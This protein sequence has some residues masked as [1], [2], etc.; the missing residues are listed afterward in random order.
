MLL[1]VTHETRYR[2][3]PAVET[4]QH[5]AHLRP[6]DTAS[7]Q[8]LRHSLTIQPEP[9]EL[10]GSADV[11]GNTRV[12]FAL[13]ATHED[14]VVVADSV[15]DTQRPAPPA[16]TMGWEQVREHFRYRA[17][18][19]FDAASE[20]VFSSPYVPRHADFFDY[21]RPSFAPGTSLLAAAA[22][23]TQR[24]H[25]DFEYAADSTE[26]NTP[27]VEALALR[28]GVCQD[29]AHIMVACFRMMGLPARY[30][31]GYL[32]TQPPPGQPRLVGADASHAWASVYVPDVPGHDGWYDFDPTNNRV[33]G[34][35]YVTLAIGRD[36]ADVSPMRGVI[37]GGA[38]HSLQVAVTVAPL[39]DAPAAPSPNQNQKQEPSS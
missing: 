33:P 34:E 11:F 2:Y 14:L 16:S 6:R 5:V 9:S 4:A 27:A 12:F 21:A 38:S 8:L 37:H 1:Q 26:V 36:Y 31:S 39:A 29:F 20:F 22:D 24:I 15:V 32:L 35:D 18:A 3:T 17:G 19:A 7:Q 13:T 30:V 10:Q 28:K 25:K 23:L